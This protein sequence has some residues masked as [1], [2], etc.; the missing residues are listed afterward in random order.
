MPFDPTLE[1]HC[2]GCGYCLAHCTTR[3]CPECGRDF[4]PN[5]PATFQPPRASREQVMLDLASQRRAHVTFFA[6]LGCM[7]AGCIFPDSAV[8]NALI[9]S[10]IV[11]SFIALLAIQTRAAMR[12][13]GSRYAIGHLVV[14]LVLSPVGLL[15]PIVIP[16][17][18]SLDL[19][20]VAENR[21]SV[22]D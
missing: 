17:L 22:R 15:G 2:L 21:L 1:I 5:D 6:S 10:F 9:A 8:V 12:T 13:L 14:A 11:G 4:D 16:F 18:V 3:R 19:R 20:R 7:V